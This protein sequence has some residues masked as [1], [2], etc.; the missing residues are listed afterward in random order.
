MDRTLDVSFHYFSREYTELKNEFGL[1]YDK[2]MEGG[3]YILGEEVSLFEK[4]FAS[5]IGVKHCIGVGN[6]LDALRL[7]LEA[8]GVRNGDEV[9]VPANTYIATWL[10]ASH[11]GAI[12]VPVDA[13]IETY[14]INVQKI[15]SAIT[16]KTKAIIPVH[17]YSHPA[18]MQQINELAQE[19][20][21]FV[22]E[23]AAQS[24]GSRLNNRMSG[25]LG[26]AAGFSF[27]PTKKL[28]GI[29]G[30]RSGYYEQ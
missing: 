20:G 21:I 23:D 24:H 25:A 16:S 13:S 2:V 10:A 30:W 17:L 27:Y 19:F 7:S 11:C 12:P 28:G 14:N 15:R 5:F 3:R 29:R 26:D 6:G 1:A 22:L 9:I 8:Y 18:Q 4:E